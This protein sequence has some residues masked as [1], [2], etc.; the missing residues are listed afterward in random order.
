MVKR[1][2]IAPA[3]SSALGS[4]AC[5]MPQSPWSHL[6]MEGHSHSASGTLFHTRPRKP[7]SL[8]V[9]RAGGGC[10]WLWSS[11]PHQR[12][13]GRRP[14]SAIYQVSFPSHLRITATLWE[15]RNIS[16][17]REDYNWRRQM[18]NLKGSKHSSC[19]CC[20]A[21][22]DSPDRAHPPPLCGSPDE[23]R[24]KGPDAIEP[25]PPLWKLSASF[26]IA[27]RGHVSELRLC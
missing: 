23:R 14:G 25:A 11:P 6:Q 10:T 20:R 27:M 26:Q 12:P 5:H 2:L 22:G 4:I 16:E 9:L 13:E 21:E 15:R 8:R 7:L 17:I 1:S 19:R 18:I 3:W 24:G